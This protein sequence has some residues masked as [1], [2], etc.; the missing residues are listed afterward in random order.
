[1]LKEVINYLL[2]SKTGIYVDGTV[3]GAGHSYAILKETDAFLVGID[4]D[5]QALQFAEKR[6][7]EFG[8]R[9]IL[10]KDN[11]ANLD[12][13]LKNLKIEKVMVFSWT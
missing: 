8:S 13:I 5:E 12:N 7:A 10:T 6:L 1:M 4:C 11:F 9:K 2:V 3:G